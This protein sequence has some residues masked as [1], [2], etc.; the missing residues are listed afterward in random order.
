MGASCTVAMA[1]EK[2]ESGLVVALPPFG[3]F[4]S[5]ALAVRVTRM[6]LHR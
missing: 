2:Y 4:G 6:H 3:K 5:S 1:T